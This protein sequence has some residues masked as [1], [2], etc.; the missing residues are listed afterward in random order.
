MQKFPGQCFEADAEE[1]S[2]KQRDFLVAGLSAP[3]DEGVEALVLNLVT[4][5]G[6]WEA[7]RCCFR[8]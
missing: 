4:G 3:G 1:S 8:R 7:R 2:V 6:S 5:S